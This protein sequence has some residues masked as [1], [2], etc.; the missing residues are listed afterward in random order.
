MRERRMMIVGLALLLGSG[1]VAGGG[2]A[3]FFYRRANVA[4]ETVVDQARE[5]ERLN[6]LLAAREKAL[7]KLR[8]EG[9][10]P[11]PVPAAL[12]GDEAAA[13]VADLEAELIDLRNRLAEAED[14]QDDD[15]PRS[16][17]A[18][19]VAAQDPPRNV[20]D[21]FARMKEND[22][23]RYARMQEQIQGRQ[24]QMIDAIAKRSAYFTQLDPARMTPEQAQK[25]EKLLGLMAQNWTLAQR[26]TE[27]P[28]SLDRNEIRQALRTNLREM[29]GLMQNAREVALEQLGQ[30][31][32][33]KGEQVNEFKEQIQ[34]IYDMTS[35]RDL[36]SNGGGRGNRGG[37][38]GAA[39]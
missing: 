29:G 19:T 14:R 12:S 4:D 27:D 23:E 5:I 17:A 28:E 38:S 10:P 20:Q 7:D 32:G 24:T 25:H 16:R 34:Q 8:Q 18:E 31:V 11:A 1:A 3:L 13:R 36:F 33:Y 6:A 21:F 15:A 2:A 35:G 26:M 39:R 22:P 30:A 9:L 37:G